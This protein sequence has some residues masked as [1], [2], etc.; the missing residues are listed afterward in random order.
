MR[1][2]MTI[3]TG[4]INVITIPVTM[5]ASIEGRENLPAIPIENSMEIAVMTD[6]VR[7]VNGNDSI[8][9]IQTAQVTLGKT[10][11][12]LETITRAADIPID[13]LIRMI[14]EDTVILRRIAMAGKIIIATRSAVVGTMISIPAMA[15]MKSGAGRM[16]HRATSVRIAGVDAVADTRE[17]LAATRVAMNGKEIEET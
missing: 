4:S 13:T 5:I 17:I 1:T 11:L 14:A 10:G 15:V 7:S 9:T 2:V 8:V 3:E 16:L 12:A 6:I